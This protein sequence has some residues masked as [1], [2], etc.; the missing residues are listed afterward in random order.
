MA[1]KKKEAEMQIA[2]DQQAKKIISVPDRFL[3]D[4][5]SLKIGFESEVA[6]HSNHLALDKLEATRNN[7]LRVVPD[8]TDVELGAAQLEFRTPPIDISST[9]GFHDISNIYGTTFQ[10][11]VLSAKKNDCSILRIGSNPFLPIKN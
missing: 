10:S 3:K 7:I 6:I 4:G 2:F 9:S 8:L 1:S 5:K 11:L